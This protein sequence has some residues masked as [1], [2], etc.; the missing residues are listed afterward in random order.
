MEEEKE[1]DFQFAIMLF[2]F[3]SNQKGNDFVVKSE[4]KKVISLLL[5]FVSV[6]CSE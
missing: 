1:K 2:F 6:F 3:G 4:K 5:R